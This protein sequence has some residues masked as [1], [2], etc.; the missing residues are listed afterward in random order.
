MSIAQMLAS[1]SLPTFPTVVEET[2]IEEIQPNIQEEKIEPQTQSEQEKIVENVQDIKDTVPEQEDNQFIIIDEDTIVFTAPVQ[3]QVESFDI[4]YEEPKIELPQESFVEPLKSEVIADKSNSIKI[5]APEIK[6]SEDFVISYSNTNDNLSDVTSKSEELIGSVTQP[7]EEVVKVT[8][9]TID[10]VAEIAPV[11]TI[12]ANAQNETIPQVSDEKISNLLPVIRSQKATIEDDEPSQKVENVVVEKHADV[13]L[14]DFSIP[15]NKVLEINPDDEVIVFNP[16]TLH[17]PTVKQEGF[18][19]DFAKIR[20]RNAQEEEILSSQEASN[21][22]EEQGNTEIVVSNGVE[23]IT[24]DED[25]NNAEPVVVTEPEPVQQTEQT[26]LLAQEVEDN[27]KKLTEAD[28]TVAELPEMPYEISKSD[29]TEIQDSETQKV[30]KAKKHWFK[31][32]EK[33]LVD[34]ASQMQDDTSSEKTLSEFL[35]NSSDENVAEI[36]KSKKVKKVKKEKTLS[37]VLVNNDSETVEEIYNEPE[38]EETAVEKK[39]FKLFGKKNKNISSVESVVD[40]SGED[41]I[42]QE[43]NNEEIQE[44]KTEKKKFNWFKRNKKSKE[45]S[46]ELENTELLPVEEVKSGS[47]FDYENDVEVEDEVSTENNENTVDKKSRK[48]FNR[49]GSKSRSNAEKDRKSFWKRIFSKKTVEIQ[50][51]NSNED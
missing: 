25:T 29:S 8:P 48:L 12:V 24:K 14:D 28:L 10:T 39:K 40:N 46:T 37:D 50:E 44:V 36:K 4:K 38:Q 7:V 17:T 6:E 1:N 41:D 3:K 47:L 34:E 23:I 32:K 49:R 21:D 18:S 5:V 13:N 51:E 11:E 42:Q 31:K 27:V 22:Y 16:K 33:V 45:V 19:Y 9:D 43:N 26:S 20:N 35:A 15:Q 30:K 2:K